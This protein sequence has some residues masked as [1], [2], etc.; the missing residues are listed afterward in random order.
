MCRMSL[1][2]HVHTRYLQFIIRKITQS[3][4]DSH[5]F[6]ARNLCIYNKLLSISSLLGRVLNP[7][8]LYGRLR[9]IQS[10]Q[11]PPHNH[12]PQISSSV[13]LLSLSLPWRPLQKCVSYIQRPLNVSVFLHSPVVRRTTTGVYSLVFVSLFLYLGF[14]FHPL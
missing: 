3:S 11:T 14:Q 8:I 2:F 1:I 13:W 5:C 12:C 6:L 7:Q 10:C 4:A 9:T